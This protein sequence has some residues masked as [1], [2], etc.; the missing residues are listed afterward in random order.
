MTYRTH[1]VYTECTAR[2]VHVCMLVCTPAA[3][4]NV[5]TPAPDTCGQTINNLLSGVIVSPT[6]PGMY[7]DH[8][9]CFYKINGP[10]GQRV[11]L[12]FTEIDLYAGGDQYVTHTHAH[13]LTHRPITDRPIQR[14]VMG[15]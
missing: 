12:T 15:N 8:I 6:Y 4:Y 7:P 10:P 2:Y 3:V 14:A 1:R 5:G 13:K 9:F 11:R